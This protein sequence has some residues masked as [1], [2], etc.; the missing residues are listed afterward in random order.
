MAAVDA[1][2]QMLARGS[3]KDFVLQDFWGFGYADLAQVAAADKTAIALAAIEVTVVLVLLAGL[4]GG[5]PLVAERALEWP[6]I[7][8]LH[9]LMTCRQGAELTV[10]YIAVVRRSDVASRVTVV[11]TRSPASREA[12]S[13]G[14]AP[15]DIR[16]H[17]R[18][19]VAEWMVKD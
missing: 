15:V 3:L 1:G 10:T 7:Q 5:P 2:I 12:L 8:V 14:I 18:L 19:Q 6:V 16:C 9:V 4:L 11:V 17:S 13:T